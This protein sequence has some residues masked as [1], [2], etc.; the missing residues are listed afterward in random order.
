MATM[1]FSLPEDMKARFDAAYMGENKSAVLAGLVNEAIEKKQLV[2]RRKQAF[3]EFMAFRA[4]QTPLEPGIRERA[5]RESR[6]M[7]IANVG[8]H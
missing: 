2:A 7:A 6:E 1:N 3:D 4:T 5:L 8:A